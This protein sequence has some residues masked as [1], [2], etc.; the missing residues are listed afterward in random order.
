MHLLLQVE[1]NGLKFA[2]MIS[3]NDPDAIHMVTG[4]LNDDSAAEKLLNLYS[5]K[6]KQPSSHTLAKQMYWCVGE[7]PCNNDNYHI[8]SPL[9]PSSLVHA[10]HTEIPRTYI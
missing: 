6:C 10:V 3:A 9:F 8:I 2:D 7:D 1:I 5:D 4:I